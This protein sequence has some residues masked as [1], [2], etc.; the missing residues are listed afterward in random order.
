MNNLIAHIINITHIQTNLIYIIIQDK[1]D[2]H[3][4]VS[5]GSIIFQSF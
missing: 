5:S 1:Y 4:T 2:E 3:D